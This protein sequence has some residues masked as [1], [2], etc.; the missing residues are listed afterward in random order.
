MP[1]LPPLRFNLSHTTGLVACAVALSDDVGI[2]IEWNRRPAP[3]AVARR[4]F[5]D[6]EAAAILSLP[7]SE[8][9]ERFFLYWTLKEAYV[10]AKGVGLLLPFDSFCFHVDP[11]NLNHI[12]LES[13]EDDP[14]MWRLVSWVLGEHRCS[15]AV[16]R[17]ETP[18]IVHHEWQ[19]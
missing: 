5:T 15:L 6:A 8:R 10:K 2:D 13:S 18:D 1:G 16:R 17:P 9:D 19:L 11:E 4:F 14:R 12:V 3:I 7:S